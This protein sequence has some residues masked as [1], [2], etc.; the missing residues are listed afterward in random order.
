MG[1][2]GTERRRE[3][4]PRAS[5]LA[6]MERYFGIPRTIAFPAKDFKAGYGPAWEWLAKWTLRAIS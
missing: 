1:G 4:L 5:G 2:D 6:G 3:P